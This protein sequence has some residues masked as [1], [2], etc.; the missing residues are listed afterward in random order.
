LAFFCFVPPMTV[1]S[2]AQTLTTLVNFNSP[3]SPDLPSALV[4]GFDGNLYGATSAGVATGQCQSDSCGTVFRMTPDGKVT[5][6]HS[7]CTQ[8]NCPDSQL[9]NVLVEGTN[10]NLYGTTYKGGGCPK[11]YV[12]CGTVFQID[13][14][15]KFSTLHS[16]CLGVHSNCPDGSSPTGLMQAA[17]GVLYGTTAGGGAYASGTVFQ[18]TTGVS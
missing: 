13:A 17:N 7:F 6:L 4:Q 3:P 1:A 12:N 14:A 2:S 11:Q 5:T 8:A 10:G 15:G 16:F 18:I 9:P